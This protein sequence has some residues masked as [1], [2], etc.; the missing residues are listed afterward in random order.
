[1]LE[2]DPVEMNIPHWIARGAGNAKQ[3]GESRCNDFRRGH[4]FARPWPVGEYPGLAIQMP[5]AGF[6]QHLDCVLKI[7]RQSSTGPNV[8]ICED[9]ERGQPD[10]AVGRI[11]LFEAIIGDLPIA[12]R[13][14]LNLDYFFPWLDFVVA[15]RHQVIPLIGAKIHL[16]QTIEWLGSVCVRATRPDSPLVIDPKIAEVLL[17]IAYLWEFRPP[18]IA[19]ALG[20]TA[21]AVTTAH[22]RDFT[23]I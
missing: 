4:V 1:M 20:P 2:V 19:F 10:D 3:R 12:E 17:L 13:H 15:Q 8:T 9:G 5:F 16:A 23:R 18:Y 14:Q 6:I 21:D 11:D 7:T 22:D